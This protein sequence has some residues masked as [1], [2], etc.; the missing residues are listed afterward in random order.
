MHLLFLHITSSDTL[1]SKQQLNCRHNFFFVTSITGYRVEAQARVGPTSSSMGGQTWSQ[2]AY[3]ANPWGAHWVSS[4]REP[5][6]TPP[7]ETE[8]T[9]DP[10]LG[11]EEAGQK[12][13]ERVMK[14]TK[15]ELLA[16][17]IPPRDWD[18]CSHLLIQYRVCLSDNLPW[19]AACNHAR[20]DY[21]H[22]QHD[23]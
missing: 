14:V 20:E 8:R 4:I 5:E 12:R 6:T 2:I 9:F 10:H 7:C 15:E 22:C 3:G 23:E 21:L 1:A 13:K 16:A 17:N 18:F 19:V 11:F